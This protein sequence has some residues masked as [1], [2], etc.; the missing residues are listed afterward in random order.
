M[1][2]TRRMQGA[3]E[4]LLPPDVWEDFGPPMAERMLVGVL[5]PSGWPGFHVGVYV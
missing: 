1:F 4:L 5:V 2:T 3:V